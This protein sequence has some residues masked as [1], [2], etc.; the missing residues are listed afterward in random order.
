MGIREATRGKNTRQCKMVQYTKTEAPHATVRSMPTR[1]LN[2]TD[3]SRA[4]ILGSGGQSNRRRLIMS[5][6]LSRAPL[7]SAH[8]AL[9][10]PRHL[11][12]MPDL[13]L[14]ASI[15]TDL[16]LIENCFE[17]MCAIAPLCLAVHRR[18]CV[19]TVLIYSL[20]VRVDPLEVHRSAG[21]CAQVVDEHG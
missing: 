21:L 18:Y 8:D 2:V 19:A 7:L 13:L 3:R 9:Q 10:R 1:L 15:G 12:T 17:C 5:A 20:G 4:A 16:G 6:G 11:P 14:T